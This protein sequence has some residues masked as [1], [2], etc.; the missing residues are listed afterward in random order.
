MISKNFLIILLQKKAYYDTS[1]IENYVVTRG[2]LRKLNEGVTS[3]AKVDPENQRSRSTSVAGKF[4]RSKLQKRKTVYIDDEISEQLEKRGVPGY[5]GNQSPSVYGRLQEEVKPVVKKSTTSNN[6]QVMVVKKKFD[7]NTY[8]NYDMF[9][10][11]K[12]ELP[13]TDF[14]VGFDGKDRQTT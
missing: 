11:M 1:L 6:S 12:R 2:V 13:F 14:V 4:A 3:P 5:P 10:D 7:F 8:Y 9:P